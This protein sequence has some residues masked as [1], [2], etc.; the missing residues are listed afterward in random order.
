MP[1]S[2]VVRE[3][4]QWGGNVRLLRLGSDWIGSAPTIDAKRLFCKSDPI[5]TYLSL[6]VR[7]TE[8]AVVDHIWTATRLTGAV[9]KSNDANGT[10]GCGSEAWTV[11]SRN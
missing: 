2:C 6:R 4:A 5:K 9:R 11:T 7:V 3:P 10:C 1:R 8:S